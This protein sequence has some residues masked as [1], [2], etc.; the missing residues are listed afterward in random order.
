MVTTSQISGHSGQNV[1]RRIQSKG[2]RISSHARAPPSSKYMRLTRQNFH[3]CVT[4]I[5]CLNMLSLPIQRQ[6]FVLL[7]ILCKRLKPAKACTL[8]SSLTSLLFPIF[9]FTS[10]SE[11][12]HLTWQKSVWA[13][14]FVHKEVFSSEISLRFRPH[15]NFAPRLCIFYSAC[16]G[17]FTF[18]P[19]ALPVYDFFSHKNRPCFAP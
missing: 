18:I 5:Y 2:S 13:R 19:N 14:F 15:T 3:E 7:Y 11:S 10:D 12:F 16:P 4:H 1:E 9:V 17:H 6:W 8:T